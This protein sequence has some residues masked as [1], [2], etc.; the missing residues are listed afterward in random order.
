MFLSIGSASFVTITNSR[1][2]FFQSGLSALGITSPKR[3]KARIVSQIKNTQRGCKIND[4]I[5]DFAN[6]TSSFVSLN[7]FGSVLRPY[8]VG[9]SV[10]SKSNLLLN[11][12]M[13]FRDFKVFDYYL[14]HIF[15]K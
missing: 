11:C 15:G 7:E 4:I 3:V 9:S 10:S 14:L 1:S 13:F 8:F 2:F 6:E 12:V 5:K